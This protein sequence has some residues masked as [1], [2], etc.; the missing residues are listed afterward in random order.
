MKITSSHI[1]IDHDA[2]IHN[3]F[4]IKKLAPYSKILVMIKANAF[5]HGLIDVA[6]T[7]ETYVE[8]L[9]IARYE[10]AIELINCRIKSK[11]VV[12]SGDINISRMKELI[13]RGCDIV[14]SSKYQFDKL[15]SSNIHNKTTIWLK[16]NTGMNRLGILLEDANSI[17]EKLTKQ[18]WVQ[19]IIL[20]TH[21]SDASM[22]NDKKTVP[23]CEAIKKLSS[24]SLPLSIANSAAIIRYPQFH[25]DWVRPGI[26]LYGASP[27][28]NTV[29]SDYNLK[30]TMELNSFLLDIRQ[31]QKGDKIG[32]DSTWTCPENMLLGIIPLGYGDGYPRNIREGTPV[33]VNEAFCPIVGKVSMDLITIDLRPVKKVKIGDLVELWGKNLSIDIIAKYANTIPNELLTHISPRLLPYYHVKKNKYV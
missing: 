16:I 4:I 5:G 2:L 6:R 27:F 1:K 14:I 19:E 33:W 32:Y 31:Q 3:L 25:Y 22:E 11:I 30:A 28:P 21:L 23:Q 15:M 17:I 24:Y 29:A 26:M 8:G 18:T 9:A 12:M 13:M 7:L 10:E 20:M